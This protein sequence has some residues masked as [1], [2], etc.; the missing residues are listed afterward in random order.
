M[1]LGAGEP[2]AGP[3]RAVPVTDFA[4]MVLDAAG[5]PHGRPAIVAVDGRSASGKTTLA[6]RLEQA[7]PGAATVHT[8]DVA[9]WHACFDWSELMVEGVLEPLWR[10]EAVAYR[11]PAWDA[12]DRPGAIDVPAGASVV[13]VEGVGAGRRQTAHLV[14][15]VVW[16]QCDLEV[17]ARRDEARIAAGEVPRDVVEQW[18]WEEVPFVADQRPWERAFA[19]VAGTPALPHDPEDVVVGQPSSSGAS[20][21]SAPASTASGG[22]AASSTAMRSG[23]AAASSS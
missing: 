9:W 3:W 10:G 5:R 7:I 18:M 8:D 14:D 16:V 1:R 21:R 15:A 17:R 4:G 11:P 2:A 20:A 23:S 19:V 12:R 13:L 6:R 22:C